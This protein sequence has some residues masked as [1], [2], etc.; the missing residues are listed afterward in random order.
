VLW[1]MQAGGHAGGGAEGQ[2]RQASHAQR[3][4]CML[5]AHAHIDAALVSA[6]SPRSAAAAVSAAAASGEV[7]FLRLGNGGGGRECGDEVMSRNCGTSRGERKR[8]RDGVMRDAGQ[9]EVRACGVPEWVCEAARSVL[10]YFP[11]GA[12]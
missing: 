10:A 3:I 1:H 6:S 5:W 2:G 11:V 7:V 4:L 9:R 12:S 8:E